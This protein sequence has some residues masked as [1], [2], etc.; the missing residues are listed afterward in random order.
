MYVFF[1]DTFTIG[2]S[3][4]RHN[5]RAST[6]SC[7]ASSDRLNPP[8]DFINF[9][10]KKIR[11]NSSSELDVTSK[12]ASTELDKIIIKQHNPSENCTEYENKRRSSDLNS[13]Q[14]VCE[15]Q[16]GPKVT[17]NSEGHSENGSCSEQVNNMKGK[18]ESKKIK[19]KRNHLLSTV[20]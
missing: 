4:N 10:R 15:N 17:H 12:S 18:S 9:E 6:S 11:L 13:N 1:R 7:Q 16:T 5:K 3:G 20:S 19:L 8:P 14:M 2:V